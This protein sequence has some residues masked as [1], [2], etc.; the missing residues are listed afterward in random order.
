MRIHA[1][2]FEFFQDRADVIVIGLASSVQDKAKKHAVTRSFFEKDT[3]HLTVH[4]DYE[5]ASKG[6]IDD[7]HHSAGRH[8]AFVWQNGMDRRSQSAQVSR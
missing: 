4:E 3:P 2:V 5:L 8:R 6:E 1:R 7:T